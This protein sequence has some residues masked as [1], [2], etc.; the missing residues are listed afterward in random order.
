MKGKGM[1]DTFSIN[2]FGSQRHIKKP[3][4]QNKNLFS[5]KSNISMNSMNGDKG[6]LKR[7][8]SLGS[9]KSGLNSDYNGKQKVQ[10]VGK[11]LLNNHL[12][13]KLGNAFMNQ[14]LGQGFMS[15]VF[16]F[17]AATGMNEVT[18]N[19][20]DS[21]Q[22]LPVGELLQNQMQNQLQNQTAVGLLLSHT[23]PIDPDADDEQKKKGG[24][25]SEDKG[26]KKDDS[27]S[28]EDFK[29]EQSYSYNSDDDHQLR[30]GGSSITKEPLKGRNSAYKHDFAEQMQVR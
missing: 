20:K 18:F 17:G 12:R 30:T 6:M 27:A 28:F 8:N 25:K 29:T 1:V 23:Q 9:R 10:Q 26:Q 7:Q 11:N 15:A 4:D 16:N 3:N 5:G 14:H 13:G 24:D 2:L 19:P 22:N 21:E